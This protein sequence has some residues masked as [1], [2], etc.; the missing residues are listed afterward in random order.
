MSSI[1]LVDV[2]ITCHFSVVRNL[3]I[4]LQTYFCTSVCL[5]FS[6]ILESFQVFFHF[7]SFHVSQML[8]KL[9]LL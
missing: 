5:L 3:L 6:D 9:H 8:L 4:S 1:F 7:V 2:K